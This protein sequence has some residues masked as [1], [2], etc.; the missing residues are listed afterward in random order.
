VSRRHLTPSNVLTAT[1]DP[2]TPTLLAGDLYYNTSTGRFRIYNGTIWTDVHPPI[3][4][5][6][7]SV[8]GVL[9]VATGKSRIYLEGSY[10]IET[11]RTAVNTAPTGASLIVDV[12]KNGTTIYT[13]QGAR[14]T[15]AASSFTATGNS[16][17]VTTFVAGDYLTVDVDQIGS[18][19]AGSD[20]TVTIRLRRVS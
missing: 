15:I 1:A 19:V 17:A 7:M 11:V 20:L 5:Y 9:T 3:E 4:C 10:V 2:A 16:P 18:T 6:T 8:T 13:T 12:N 14:P